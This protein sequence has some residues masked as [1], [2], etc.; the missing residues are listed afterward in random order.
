MMAGCEAV[1]G[2]VESLTQ[3]DMLA[4]GLPSDYGFNIN[5][6]GEAGQRVSVSTDE[7]V[8]G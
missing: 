5:L 1:K 7:R 8:N 3:N 6:A 4:V 2:M